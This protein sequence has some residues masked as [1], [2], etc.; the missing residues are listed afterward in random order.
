MQNPPILHGGL[1]NAD[2]LLSQVWAVWPI[3][4]KN[5]RRSQLILFFILFLMLRLPYA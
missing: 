5:V 4:F 2:L 3:L 1:E